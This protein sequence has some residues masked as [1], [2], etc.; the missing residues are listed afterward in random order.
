M[1]EVEKIDIFPVTIFK[2]KSRNHEIIKKYMIDKVYDR[3]VK[4]G[5]NDEWQQ[6][7]TDY[8]PGAAM[9]HWPYL[10]D[11]YQPDVEEILKAIGMQSHVK[12]DVRLT[13][14]YNFTT[15]CEKNF[16]H[17]HMG[18]PSVIN[19]AMVHYVSLEKDTHGTVFQNPNMKLMKA[20]CPTKDLTKLPSYWTGFNICPDVEEGDIVIFPSWLDHCI[21]AHTNGTLRITNAV[22][23][24]LRAEDRDGL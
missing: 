18:G 11:L 14:W 9:V 6:T 24:I 16:I 3:F 15:H 8:V 5:C 4:D 13:G 10:F 23:I 21:P 7:Y 19:L 12:W 2:I 1:S 22:N 17:D 20:S